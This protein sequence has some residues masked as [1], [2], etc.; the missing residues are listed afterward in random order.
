MSKLYVGNISLGGAMTVN[1]FV[2]PLKSKEFW[3]LVGLI[4]LAMAISVYINPYL[5]SWKVPINS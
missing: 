3:V 5:R 4:V 1:D 2:G